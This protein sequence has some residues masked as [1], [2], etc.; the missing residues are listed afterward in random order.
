M[1]QDR[2]SGRIL[3]DPVI[4][5]TLAPERQTQPSKPCGS[6]KGQAS[7][8]LLQAG[9]VHFSSCRQM[10]FDIGR[11]PGQRRS[12]AGYGVHGRARITPAP[13]WY[14]FMF[15]CRWHHFVIRRPPVFEA[16]V[17]G[18]GSMIHA[19]NPLI[20]MGV[21]AST[22]ATDAVYVL[23]TAAVAARRRT[24]AASW[25]SVWYLLSAFAV[26][27]YTGNAI[28]VCLCRAWLL[29][30]S[31]RRG[32]MAG[33]SGCKECFRKAAGELRVP[34]RM[35]RSG[36]FCMNQASVTKV[37]VRTPRLSI[38]SK[39][40]VVPHGTRRL[41][42]LIPALTCWAITVPFLR[43]CGF[44]V[45]NVGQGD[46]LT[47]QAQSGSAWE[48]IHTD[49]MNQSRRD[50]TICS[51]ARECRVQDQDVRNRSPHRGRH[52]LDRRICRASGR[53][54]AFVVSFAKPRTEAFSG[55]IWPKQ[56]TSSGT[57]SR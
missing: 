35:L 17:R 2:T 3:L 24:V 20:A 10:A 18:E 8:R 46:D 42:P 7:N 45:L 50:G 55:E 19:P 23:F 44:G 43:N 15:C 4:D 16:S 34:G 51:P 1:V 22:A 26:I 5:L 13:G 29:A 54:R 27:S 41:S 25:S 37:S 53:Q 49:S 6:A 14:G 40:C 9:T 38:M 28:Y 32:D 33:N 39:Y 48:F 52:R 31:F 30:G 47:T 56:N 11:S 12:A 36:A 57:T 21:V